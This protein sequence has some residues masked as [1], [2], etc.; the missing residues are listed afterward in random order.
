MNK[1]MHMNDFGLIS[2]NSGEIS[3]QTIEKEIKARITKNKRKQ[4]Q[5]ITW[6]DQE[7]NIIQNMLQQ[8]ITSAGHSGSLL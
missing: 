2:A 4:V 6:R 8:R 7:K 1:E 5:A 3:I